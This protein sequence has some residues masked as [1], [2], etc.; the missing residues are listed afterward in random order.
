MTV[1]TEPVG[2]LVR[3]WRQRRRRSQLDVAIGAD[4]S[5]R[6]LSFVETGRSLPSRTMIARLCD[7][8]DV[9][10]RERNRLYLAAGFAPMHP[11]RPLADLGSAR[12]AV[13]AVLTGHEPNPALAVNAR[14]E[15][16]AA[17]DAAL[18]ILGLADGPPL[19]EP[20]NVMR[21]TLHPDAL[22]P[23]VVNYEQWRA[24]VVRRIRRHA[25]RTADPALSELADEIESYPQRDGHRVD[26][27]DVGED[28]V[29]P[30]RLRTDGGELTFLYTVTVFG[31]PRD[32]TLDEIAIETFF[33]ADAA[34][35]ALLRAAADGA[36][37]AAAR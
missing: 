7:E 29:I 33:P 22:A 3:T 17:N 15:L 2:H 10:L 31:A 21:G 36:R 28:L 27:D 19:D 11:E 32:V 25:A 20:F 4:I 14:W 18:S 9:P 35:A 37:L 34:T 26:I 13:E 5:A 1:A 23:R 8:L 6:H 24:H 12:A 16:L 30:L